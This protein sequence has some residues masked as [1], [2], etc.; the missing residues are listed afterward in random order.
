MHPLRPVLAALALASCG[1]PSDDGTPDGWTADP[2]ADV[3]DCPSA[4]GCEPSDDRSLRAGAAVRSVVPSC[5]ESWTDANGDFSYRV[6]SGDTFFDCGCDRLCPG[7]EGY[8]GAD[9]GEGD[10]LFRPIWVAG[11]SQARAA[12][13]VRSAEHGGWLGEGDGLEARA[14]VLD[15]GNTRLAIVT[16]DSIGVMYDDALTIRRAVLEADLDV[17]HVVVHSSHS[18]SAPDMMGIYGKGLTETGRDPEY[19]AEIHAAALDAVVEAVG[20]LTPVEMSWGQVDSNEAFPNGSANLIRD[21]RDPQIVDPRVGAVR[22]AKPD[23]ATVATLVHWANHPETIADKNTLMTSDFVHGLRRVVSEGSSWPNG[24][25]HEGVGG[26][27]VF[28]NGTVG[29]M[30]TSLGATVVTPDGREL[31]EASWDKVDAVGQLVGE[32]ALDALAEARAVESPELRVLARSVKL[33]VV[34]L[35]FQAMFSLGVFSHRSV[36]DYDTE[37]PIDEDNQPNVPTEIDLVQIGPVH[38]LTLPGEVFP[39]CV[40]GGYEGEWLPPGG[41]LVD[42]GN[43][44]PPKLD[45]APAGPYLEAQIGGELKWVVSLGNDEIGYVIPP[46]NFE[47]GAPAYLSEAE[48]DHYEETNS[49]GPETWPVLEAASRELLEYAAS[50]AE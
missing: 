47:V 23:G 5:Y 25:T 28:L 19:A 42:E 24:D 46:Y 49:L 38:I 10:G 43:P 35:G 13:G 18:H 40:I 44:N 21:S 34:N 41:V 50:P 30:M 4:P 48:G 16:V 11:F 8:P 26:I 20:A 33:P 17:D 22:F 7:D 29:G 14:L 1:T 6:S 12:T 45:E 37:A 36:T 31:R 39:E 32:L 2:R 3:I 15:Q 9:E 27:T